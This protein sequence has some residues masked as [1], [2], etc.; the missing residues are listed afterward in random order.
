MF[1]LSLGTSSPKIFSQILNKIYVPFIP[2]A[3]ARQE[4]LSQILNKIYVPPPPPSA[5]PVPQLHS[6]GI[7]ALP[8]YLSPLTS[9][10]P[11]NDYK[12]VKF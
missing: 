8:S 7:Q 2:R 12:N 5:P 3:P 4:I 11:S 10:I 6:L 9:R 1:L